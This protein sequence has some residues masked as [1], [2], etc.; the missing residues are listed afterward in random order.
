MLSILLIPFAQLV[1]FGRM[2]FARRH[3]WVLFSVCFTIFAVGVCVAF[4]AEQHGSAVLRQSGVNITHS[5]IQVGGNMTDKE[6]RFGIANTAL[7]TTGDDRR[8]QRRRSTAVMMRSR[9]PAE[10]CL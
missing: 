9:L 2:V 4:P 5:A 1:M 7:W 8:L 10:L 3:A 6:I